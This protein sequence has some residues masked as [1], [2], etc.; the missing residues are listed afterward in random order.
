MNKK[1]IIIEG[2][3]AAGKSTFAT[4]LSKEINIPYLSK[5]TLKIALCSSITKINREESS[6]FSAVT[7]D[8]ILYM[9]ERLIERGYPIII[10]GNF[11]PGGIKKI[12]E[13]AVIK[14]LIDKYA[15]QSLTYK[16]KGDT[17]ILYKRFIERDKLPERGQVNMMTDDFT[18]DDF[19]KW[20]HNL[21]SFN[22]GG[23]IVKIDTTDFNKVDFKNLIE[24]ANSFIHSNK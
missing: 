18:Y 20:C 16:F 9:T 3:L 10:E 11:V 15:C 21:D 6:C 14:K 19:S 12:D 17:K 13:S 24:I 22:V 23:K 8:A 5:D 2:Y 1:I 7:F 4:R